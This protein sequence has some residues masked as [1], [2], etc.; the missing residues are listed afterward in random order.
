VFSVLIFTQHERKQLKT[1][2]VHID[3][4][5]KRIQTAPNCPQKSKQLILQLP[6]VAPSSTHCDCLP[7]S[8]RL[9]RV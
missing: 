7:N 4:P 8:C 2:L 3:G 5:V 1:H 6:T 9:W